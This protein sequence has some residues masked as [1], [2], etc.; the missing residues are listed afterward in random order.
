MR[1]IA[2]DNK[3]TSRLA[4]R[5]DDRMLDLTALDAG[6]PGD[7]SLLL[8]RGQQELDRL[9][10][11]IETADANKWKSMQG[12]TLLP[13]ARAAG[14]II[15]LGLNYVD[16]A[17][18]AGLQKPEHLVVFLRV[19]TSLVAHGE[20]IVRPRSSE[21]LDFEAELA[22]FIGKGGRHIAR[23]AAL[24]H[25]A[26]YGL[27]NDASIRD[28]QIRTSQWTM[29]KNFDSTGGFG[30]DFVSADEVP[31]GGKGLRIQTRL[32]G[33][34]V[35]DANTSD[36]V[37]DVAETIARVSECMTLE[38]GDLIVTGTPAG[39]G[40]ARKPPLWMRSGD[41]CEVEIERLGILRNPIVAEE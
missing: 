8:R 32:N 23:A 27:F 28:Y 14:K 1:L 35:Q 39:V 12:V 41:V 40:M 4:A 29:G 20:P 38:P 26:G 13:P 5:R 33:Q 10:T 37:F 31:P 34:V 18:E 30:P 2:F 36:M 22:A 21:Q 25:V 17:A 16:H 24:D 9:R 19:A 3:G 11:L 15:C 6:L 7:V